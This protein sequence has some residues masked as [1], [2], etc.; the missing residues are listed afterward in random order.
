MKP[1]HWLARL[2]WVWLIIGLALG[3]LLLHGL[4]QAHLAEPAA[5]ALFWL[6][7]RYWSIP[8]KGLWMVLLLLAY[9]LFAASLFRTPSKEPWQWQEEALGAERPLRRLA[10]WLE[11]SESAHARN[12]LRQVV[13]ELS[14]RV[15]AE[16]LDRS[17]NQVK[18]EILQGTL[19]LPQDV[20]SYLC[21]GLAINRRVG[22]DGW[23]RLP[24]GVSAPAAQ[25]VDP[26]LIATLEFLEQENSS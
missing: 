13:A 1:G 15:L 4:V 5:R 12:R 25:R 16:R 26:R 24:E 6:R 22:E 14:V 17:R 10:R 19:S 23:L 21:E 20:S 18:S 9:L 11:R 8:Q 7:L 3:T 2:W